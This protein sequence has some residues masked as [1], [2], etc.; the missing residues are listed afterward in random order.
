MENNGNMY[1]EKE[2]NW[3]KRCKII[4]L[5]PKLISKHSILTMVFQAPEKTIIVPSGARID[6]SEVFSHAVT[7]D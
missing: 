2:G 1:S 5:P 6:I 3:I 7:S 4:E